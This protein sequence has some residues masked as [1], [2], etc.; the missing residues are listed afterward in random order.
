MK[1]CQEKKLRK[2]NSMNFVKVSTL[3]VA[4]FMKITCKYVYILIS[5]PKCSD[6]RTCQK[7]ACGVVSGMYKQKGNFFLIL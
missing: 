3:Q 2:K 7:W 1:Y 4:L 6:R 5:L